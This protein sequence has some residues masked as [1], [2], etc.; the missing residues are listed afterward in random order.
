MF[1][2]VD[3]ETT[4]LSP[5]RDRIL[6]V[7]IAITTDDLEIKHTNSKLVRVSPTVLNTLDPY[8]QKM[9]TKSGLLDELLNSESAFRMSEEQ[10]DWF[11]RGWLESTMQEFYEVEPGTQPMCGSSVHFDRAFL[12]AHMPRLEDWFSYRNID[13]SCIKELALRWNSEVAAGIPKPARRH[14]ALSDIADTIAELK[15]YGQFMF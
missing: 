2:F 7:G 14:R 4:G 10:L 11:L 15:Y 13:V 6:E 12:Q 3:I 1:V 9:H 8:V 5:K